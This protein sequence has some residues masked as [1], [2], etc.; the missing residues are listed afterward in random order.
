MLNRR[1]LRIKVMQSVY[2]LLQSKSDDI[3]KEQKFLNY[4]INKIYDLYVLQLSLLAEVRNLAEKHQEIGK[5]KYLAT[6]EDKN[7][8]RKFIDHPFLLGLKNNVSLQNYI[9]NQKLKNWKEDSEYVRLIWDAIRESHIYADFIKSSEHTSPKGD[10]NFISE[11]YKNVIAPNDK[12][13]DYYE[14]QLITW[15]DDIPFVNTWIL[16]NLKK[17]TANSSFDK[18]SLYKNKDDE[19]FGVALFKKT[20]LH[21]HEFMDDID[22]KTPNWDTDRIAEVDFILMKMALTELIY[23][24][25]IPTRVTINEYIE[26]AK[27]YSTTKSSFFINGVLDK[28][29]KEYSADDK[30]KKIGRGL[31]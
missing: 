26:I 29:L 31:L 7:P 25:S 9:K 30:I 14:S 19:E 13:F 1:H 2:A 10:L 11:L 23:F 17:I 4:S 16:K 20:V 27:D 3:V 18:N 24:P 12:L 21:H 5:K 28:L 8:N 15:V 6:S 22:A